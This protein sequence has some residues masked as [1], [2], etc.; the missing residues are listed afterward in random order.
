MTGINV[1]EEAVLEQHRTCI[2]KL[3]SKFR[4]AC[5]PGILTQPFINTDIKIDKM[6]HNCYLVA[7]K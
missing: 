1:R 7:K 6:E 4:G 2:I 5:P 3:H